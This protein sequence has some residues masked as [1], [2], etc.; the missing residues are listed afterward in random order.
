MFKADEERVVRN[1]S[2]KYSLLKLD[3]NGCVRF[4]IYVGRDGESEMEV[5]GCDCNA[6][7]KLFVC[8]VAQHLD[9]EHLFDVVQDYRRELIMA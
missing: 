8:I 1:E 3:Y 6:A 5:V 9:C 2:K 4:A 7:E